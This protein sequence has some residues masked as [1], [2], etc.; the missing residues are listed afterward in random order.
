MQLITFTVIRLSGNFDNLI[1]QNAAFDQGLCCLAL[2]HI[3]T[4][5]ALFSSENC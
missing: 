2:I 5:K 4:D 1:S 3:A